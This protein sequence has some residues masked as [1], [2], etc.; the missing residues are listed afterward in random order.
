MFIHR[1]FW[2]Y[3]HPLQ[4]HRWPTCMNTGKLARMPNQPRTPI[5]GI[6]VPDELWTAAQ[7][8]AATNDESV[9][10]VV[11]R[12]LEAYVKDDDGE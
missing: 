7:A 2:V 5:R 4:S 8:A 3:A 10:D 9:S 6:R 11:R 12:A 1:L